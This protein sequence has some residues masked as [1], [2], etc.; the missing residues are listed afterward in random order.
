MDTHGPNLAVEIQ[1]FCAKAEIFLLDQS[2]DDR[3]RHR[4]LSKI[5]VA[6]L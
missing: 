2:D 5:F 1:E 4:L 6:L 3:I